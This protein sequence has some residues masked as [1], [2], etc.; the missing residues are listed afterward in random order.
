MILTIHPPRRDCLLVLSSLVFC[1]GLTGCSDS[2]AVCGEGLTLCEGIC[3]DLTSESAHC[4]ACGTICGD[5]QACVEGACRCRPGTQLCG[6]ACVDT[7]SSSEHC[8]GCAG[9]GGTTCAADQVCEQGQCGQSCTREGFQRCGNSCVDLETDSGHC[10]GCGNSCGDARACRGGVCTYDVVATCFNS[11][12]VVGIRSGVDIK[13]PGTPVSSSPQTVARMSDVLL[14]LDSTQK[15]AQVRLSDY[16]ALPAQNATGRVP[17]QVIVRD[18]YVYVINSIDNVLQVLRRDEEPTPGGTGSPRFPDGITLT[19]VASLDFGANTNPFA[20]TELGSELWVTLYGNLMGNPSAG[21][22]VAR[23]SLAGPAQPRVVDVIDLPTGEALRPF[24]GSNPIPTPAGITASR[25][26]L[27]VTLNNL[28]PATFSPGGPGLLARIDPE[29]RSVHLI[30]LGEGCS[31]PGWISPLGDQLLVSC[32]GK[33]RYDTSYNLLSVE[34]SGM[35]LLDAADQVVSTYRLACP[36]GASNCPIPAAGRFALVGRRA[37]LGD[38]N[39][40]RIFVLDVEGNTLIERRGL[41][42][43]AEAPIL[44]CPS[45]GYSLVSDVVALP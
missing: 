13:G 27:Y 23:V 17:N 32:N 30:D 41:G 5:N 43:T 15:L 6:E 31:N 7:N 3:V 14:V 9:V 10:G 22:R 18:P 45:S 21:G 28:D 39:G 1:L 19:N 33:A 44:A 24:P 42:P 11:G 38:T 8:G 37:Y 2:G 36:E 29:S 16:G 25:G 40:G 20:M 4:G 34:Q 35:V 26:R 12:Q